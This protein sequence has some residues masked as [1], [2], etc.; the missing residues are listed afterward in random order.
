MRTPALGGGI[1][2]A[3]ENSLTI[4]RE[5]RVGD[6]AEMPEILIGWK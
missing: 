1:E 5:A 2:H 3:E 4:G 6:T